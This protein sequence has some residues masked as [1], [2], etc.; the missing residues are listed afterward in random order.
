[1]RS[2]FVLL[3]VGLAL[4]PA[5]SKP[6]PSTQ[7]ADSAPPVVASA[8]PSSESIAKPSQPVFS[9]GDKLQVEQRDRPTGTAKAEDVYAAFEKAGFAL[10]EKQQHVASVFG[11]KFCLGA[12][13]T[14]D[15]A[16]SV[17]EYADEAAAKAGRE[18]S[19]KA[20]AV[21][22]NRDILVN[23]KTMLTV[24]QPA[25]KTPASEAAEKKAAQV[26]SAL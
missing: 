9:L 24:R 22:P 1:M 18:T 10:T 4:V 12:K 26:F 23:K 21:V 19:L 14:N 7:V 16:F 15:M 11:A 5:C 25:T 8:V 20:L 17:C 13:T 6:A 2:M 3:M